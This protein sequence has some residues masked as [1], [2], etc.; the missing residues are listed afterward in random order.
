MA[1]NLNKILI[2]DVEATCWDG[3][4]PNGQKS[5]I[6]EVG[7]VEMSLKDDPKIIKSHDFIVRPVEST[8]SPFCTGLT[9]ITQDLVDNGNTLEATCQEINRIGDKG[10]IAWASW[11]DY[12][13][14]QFR[15]ECGRKNIRYPFGKTHINLKSLFA[16]FHGLNKEVGMEAA[17][18]KLGIQLKGTHHRAIDDATN[19]AV[20]FARML[21]DY[22]IIRTCK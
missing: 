18:G 2:V 6:I 12:D 15:R 20:I 11:G 16:I 10:K 22:K 7:L 14:S 5:E 1:R 13:A 17:L 19:I 4:P 3:D 21:N 9:T 8:V